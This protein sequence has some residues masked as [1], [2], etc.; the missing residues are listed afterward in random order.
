[1]LIRAL[2]TVDFTQIRRLCILTN[3]PTLTAAI[4][5]GQNHFLLLQ[6]IFIA[7]IHLGHMILRNYMWRLKWFPFAANLLALNRIHLVI[8]SV[9]INFVLLEIWFN[10]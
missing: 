2:Y 3:G 4:C 10:S 5:F 9:T 7:G 1:M 6:A 8:L